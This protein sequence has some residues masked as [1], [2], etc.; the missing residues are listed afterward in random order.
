MKVHLYTIAWNEMKMLGFFFRHYD[1]FVD[2]YVVFDDGSTDGTLEALR[3][4]PRV[5]VRRFERRVPNSFVRSSQHLNNHAW[6]ESRGSADWV[7]VSAV[8]EHLYHRDLSGYLEAAKRAGVTAIPSLGYE[9]VSAEFPR[10]DETLVRSCTRGAPEPRW[11][12]LN[13]FN[14]NAVRETNYVVG[15]H[16]AWPKGKIVYP[17]SD[18]LLLLHYK[19]I[20]FNYLRRRHA[21]LATGLGALD[22]ANEW[23]HQFDFS[24]TELTGKLASLE[25]NAVDITT[26][27]TP[28]QHHPDARWWRLSPITSWWRHHPALCALRQHPAVRR[29]WL[30]WR[31]RDYQ[32]RAL[33]NE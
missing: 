9:M 25:N 29:S 22:H 14:P 18:E 30:R 10:P 20:E 4:H 19:Y 27:D 6:K 7:V 31:R 28:G 3:D 11:N 5:E 17:E 15:R 23:A 2:R 33:P 24:D 32:P 21:L 1:S 16:A 8:D 26:L 12:K 13:L